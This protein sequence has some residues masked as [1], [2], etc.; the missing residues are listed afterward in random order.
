MGQ[1]TLDVGCGGRLLVNA[2]RIGRRTGHSIDLAS[3]AIDAAKSRAQ[4]DQ[5]P[6]GIDR[7]MRW[8]L[9]FPS[10]SFD[11]VV[12]TDVLV[13]VPNPRKAVSEMVRVLRP[14]GHIFF[15]S[16]NRTWWA[17]FVML[18]LGERWLRIVPKGTHDAATFITPKDSGS[19]VCRR[20]RSHRDEPR[21]R[22]G[23]LVEGA[24]FGPHPFRTVMY[25][26]LA[27]CRRGHVNAPS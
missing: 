19:L 4:H 23:R 21:H 27:R 22:S 12:S 9:P 16:I 2:P 14:G 10:G 18:T 3:G 26:G 1:R 13:H 5:L 17:R 11:L 24:G 25:Q 7:V 15:S 20:G 6:I 8:E